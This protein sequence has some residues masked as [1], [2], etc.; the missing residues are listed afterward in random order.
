MSVTCNPV[1]AFQAVRQNLILKVLHQ[2]AQAILLGVN[3]TVPLR[4][5]LMNARKR[6]KM[7]KFIWISLTLHIE[8]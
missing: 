8:S 3:D 2:V 7:S 1:T 6:D 4:K 5:K